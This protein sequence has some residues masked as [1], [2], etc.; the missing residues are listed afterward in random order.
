MGISQRMVTPRSFN[1]SRRAVMPLKLPSLEKLRGKISY[2][3][4]SRPHGGRDRAGLAGW[5]ERLVSVAVSTAKATAS[6]PDRRHL[7]GGF[8]VCVVSGF[9]ESLRSCERLYASVK[10]TFATRWGQGFRSVGLLR[11]VARCGHWI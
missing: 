11:F 4:P 5:A 1:S 6:N 2:T 9:T 8:I 10:R 3:T 7:E